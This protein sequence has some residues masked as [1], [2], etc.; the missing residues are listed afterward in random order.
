MGDGFSLGQDSRQVMIVARLHTLNLPGVY[1]FLVLQEY[2]V[3]YAVER[4][5]VKHFSR[6]HHQL[7]STH[8]QVLITSFQL[9]HLDHSFTAF[10]HGQEVDHSRGLEG[11]I[12]QRLHC[13]FREEGQR[14][15]AANYRM[16]N[17]IKWVIVGHK[18]T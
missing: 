14:S 10:L 18:W 1:I 16:G 7:L 11:I 13:H 2:R 4:H 5:I 12:T 3:I 8:V 6:F 15:L 9:F 17:D